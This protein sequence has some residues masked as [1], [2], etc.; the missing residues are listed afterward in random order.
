MQP[1]QGFRAKGSFGIP[2]EMQKDLEDA[3]RKS[4]EAPKPPAAEASQSPVMA[5]ELSPAPPAEAKGPKVMTDAEREAEYAKIKAEL[6][7]DLDTTLTV[8]D[9]KEYVFRGRITKEVNVITGVLKCTFQTL[10]PAEHLEIDKRIAAYQDEGIYTSQGIDNQRSLVTLSY[11]FLA[12]NGKMLS[13][14][15]EPLKR[16]EAIRRLG[17]D[18]VDSVSRAYGKFKTLV[19][20]VM[21]EKNFIKKP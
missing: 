8:E 12:A 11:V 20:V 2:P 18:V 10:N 4:P 6:E 21:E 14:K 3:R 13:A 1:A 5:P 9:I 7:K 17:V 19:T 15:S 16:E